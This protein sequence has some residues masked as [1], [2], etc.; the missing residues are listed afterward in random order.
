MVNVTP[1]LAYETRKAW[2]SPIRPSWEAGVTVRAKSSLRLPTCRRSAASC[3]RASRGC[4]VWGIRRRGSCI[5]RRVCS[6]RSG[7]RIRASTGISNANSTNIRAGHAT[8]IGS[9]AGFSIDDYAYVCERLAARDEIEAVELNISCP[10]VAREGETFGCDPDLTE[11][12]VAAARSTTDKTLIVKLSPNVTDITAV[13]R[14]AERAGA[15]ALAVINTVRGMA[16]DVETLAAA[17]GQHH[18]RSL[19]SGDPADCA[20]W[21]ST[22]SRRP[23]TFRSSGKVASRASAMHSSSSWPERRRSRSAPQTLPTRA[24]PSESP[25]NF[26]P[27]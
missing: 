4:R 18:R 2:S 3:L 17:I 21:P 8:I 23:S 22:K 12:V 26:K 6:T 11:R 25:P 13:A 24:F 10:N 15:D 20:S 16:I 27:T 5:R 7:C 1:G 19:R 9:V 14:Q